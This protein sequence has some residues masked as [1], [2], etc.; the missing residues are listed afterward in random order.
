MRGSAGARDA[1]PSAAAPGA[2]AAGAATSTARTHLGRPALYINAL[3]TPYAGS[4]F[5]AGSKRPREGAM[6]TVV[7]DAR[8]IGRVSSGAAPPTVDP[9]V[10]M[11]VRSKPGQFAGRTA[12]RGGSPRRAVRA[13]GKS[14]SKSGRG[15]GRGGSGGA[16]G[17]WGRGRGR[18]RER[19]GSGS[20]G[21]GAKGGRR[22]TGSPGRGRSG[23]R[24]RGGGRGGGRG[25]GAKPTNWTPRKQQPTKT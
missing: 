5:E 18:G 21:R 11:N 17:G 19:G 23:R 13:E 4:Y 10:V 8:G 20:R 2:C 14:K 25:R 22:G 1:Q 12:P 9:H 16:R 3:R 7:V 24:G 6:R 15:R